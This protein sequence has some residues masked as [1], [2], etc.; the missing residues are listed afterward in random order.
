VHWQPHYF[1]VLRPRI[2]S[3]VTLYFLE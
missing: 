1:S 2:Y 3:V